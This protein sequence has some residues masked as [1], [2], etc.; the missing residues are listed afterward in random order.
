VSPWEVAISVA[1]GKLRLREPPIQWFLGLS[2]RY[3]LRELPLNSRLAC[4]AA[5]FGLAIAT[6]KDRATKD[7]RKTLEFRLR[8]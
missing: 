3:Q 6:L 5:L 2:E 8:G 4:A 7:M 1:R